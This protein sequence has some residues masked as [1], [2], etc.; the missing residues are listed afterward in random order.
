M[1]SKHSCLYRGNV[2]HRRQVPVR[3]EFQYGLLLFYVELAKFDTVFSG[4]WFWSTHSPRPGGLRRA[5]LPGDPLEPLQHTIERIL[6]EA[7]HPTPS[8]PIFVL[9][10][11]RIWGFVFN[12]ISLFYC[13]SSEGN[14][15]NVVAHVRNIPWGESHVYV[16]SKEHWER[17]GDHP[18]TPKSFHVSPFLPIDMT[19]SWHIQAPNEEL[20][21]AIHVAHNGVP[22]LD[23]GMRLQREEITTWTLAKLLVCFPWRSLA[24]PVKIYWQAAKLWWK[25]C[26]YYPHPKP[27]HST[28][29]GSAANKE[30]SHR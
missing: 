3:H 9:T 10:Q 13:F 23:A 4:R 26:P 16:L 20:A 5:D 12:P 14:L 8:G 2:W 25:R 6:L 17:S 30:Y 18:T 24:I 7:G 29:F 21:F 15:V 19:Y 22:T 11:P 28:P 1:K 27:N